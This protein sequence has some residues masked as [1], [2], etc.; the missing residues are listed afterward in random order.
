MHWTEQQIRH[1]L[2][3]TFTKFTDAGRVVTRKVPHD[4]IPPY[5]PPPEQ[6]QA[7]SARGIAKGPR[8]PWTE[9]DDRK[10]LSLRARGVNQEECARLL[11]RCIKVT[12][13]RIHELHRAGVAQ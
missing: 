8:R 10:L 1:A 9:D 2:D 12:R 11:R 7:S 5:D 13:A 6:K 3:G 4:F